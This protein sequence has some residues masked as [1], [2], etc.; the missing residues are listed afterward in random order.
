PPLAPSTL[1][2]MKSREGFSISPAATTSPAA[3]TATARAVSKL[4]VAVPKIVA[5]QASVPEL[6][7]ARLHAPTN[8]RIHVFIGCSFMYCLSTQVHDRPVRRDGRV[9]CSPL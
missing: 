8:A 2:T 6:N 4:D 5:C 1:L 7:H 3:S 9:P